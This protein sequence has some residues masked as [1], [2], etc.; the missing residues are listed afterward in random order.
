MFK[1]LNWLFQSQEREKITL[2]L[3]SVRARKKAFDNASMDPNHSFTG[4]R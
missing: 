3:K 2:L 1:N 4:L